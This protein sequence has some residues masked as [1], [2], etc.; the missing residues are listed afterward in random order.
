MSTTN[1][2]SIAHCLDLYGNEIEKALNSCFSSFRIG[3]LGVDNAIFGYHLVILGVK[4]GNF[5][6]NVR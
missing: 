5:P 3:I 1:P 4:P 2:R 6:K